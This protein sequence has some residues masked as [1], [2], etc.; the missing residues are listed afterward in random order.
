M[1]RKAVWMNKSR[2]AL[3]QEKAAFF[4]K[5]REG[6]YTKYTKPEQRAK[7]RN[8][9]KKLRKAEMQASIWTRHGSIILISYIQKRMHLKG[10]EV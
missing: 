1:H 3:A 5:Q 4:E 6:A 9:R 7:Y 2:M 8:F 10:K